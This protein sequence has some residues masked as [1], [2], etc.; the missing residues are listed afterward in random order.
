MLSVKGRSKESQDESVLGPQSFKDVPGG[1]AL[2]LG[3]PEAAFQ[4]SVDNPDE[5]LQLGTPVGTCSRYPDEA[6]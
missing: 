6:E 5:G 4:N 3:I 2:L 1:V